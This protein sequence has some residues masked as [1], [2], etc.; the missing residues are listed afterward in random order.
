MQFGK[1]GYHLVVALLCTVAPD[2]VLHLAGQ[3]LEHGWILAHDVAPHEHLHFLAVVRLT[4]GLLNHVIH[5]VDMLAVDLVGSAF[6]HILAGT[7]TAQSLG[8][9]AVDVEETAA[10]VGRHRV[11]YLVAQKGVGLLFRGIDIGGSVHEALIERNAQS[12][13][14][15]GKAL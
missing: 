15:M 3:F 8:L 6:A 5:A 2:D 13:L 1:W 10:V 12:F 9:I 4:V 11:F 14:K 7:A